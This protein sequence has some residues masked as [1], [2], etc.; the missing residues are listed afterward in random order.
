MTYKAACFKMLRL[1]HYSLP[2]QPRACRDRVPWAS[3]LEL[4][5]GCGPRCTPVRQL[6]AHASAPG[7]KPAKLDPL[8]YTQVVALQS[9]LQQWLPSKV[10]RVQLADP[11]TLA[12]YIRAIDRQGWLHLSWHP[13]AARV[14][15]GDEPE[16]GDASS[17]YPFAQLV[18]TKCVAPHCTAYRQTVQPPQTRHPAAA[19]IL[20]LQQSG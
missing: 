13:R 17:S 7:D 6:A 4:R 9:E 16:H 10:Q 3:A 14:C 12:L 5:P 15:L 20:Q 19:H 1:Q 8:D 11:H 2:L 18:R